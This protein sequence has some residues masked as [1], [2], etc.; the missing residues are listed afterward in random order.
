[1]MNK[2]GNMFFAAVLSAA[3]L[4]F[5][6][7]A[8]DNENK[9]ISLWGELAALPNSLTSVWRKRDSY[10]GIRYPPSSK[11]VPTFQADQVPVSCRVF[12]YLL[13]H[14]PE[15]LSGQAIAQMTEKEAMSRGADMLL[16]GGARRAAEESDEPV[17]SYYGPIQPYRCRDYWSGWNFAY[18]EWVS[19]GEWISMGYDEWGNP[20]ARFAAPLVI[21]AA[22][23]RCQE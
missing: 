6:G 19:Q 15:G 22:F 21:Q 1:M 14:I 11:V 16:I 13:V 3:S 9:T 10:T 23:L 7:C 18:E 17:F 5:S 8:R 2:Q 20:A 4:L 12:A